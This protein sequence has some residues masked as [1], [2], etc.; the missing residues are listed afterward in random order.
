MFSVPIL[1]ALWSPGFEAVEA[2]LATHLVSSQKLDQLE[3]QLQ[4]LGP[5]AGDSEQLERLFSSFQASCNLES[6]GTTYVPLQAVTAWQLRNPC[7]Q[8]GL[9][10]CSD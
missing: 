2:G 4:R 9:L 10:T 3:Q 5:R 6:G 7:P 1:F 8:T